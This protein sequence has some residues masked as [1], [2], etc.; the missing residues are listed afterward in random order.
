MPS[1][2][3]PFFL[4][5]GGTCGAILRAVDW[6]KNPLGPPENWTR[7]LQ[8]A[9]GTLLQSKHPMF[10]WWGKDLIQIYNDGYMP[11]FGLDRHPRAM[12][13]PG[14]ECWQDIW[15]VIG[16]QIE[17]VMAGGP[18][19]WHED[20]LVPIHRYGRVEEVYWTYSF[21]PVYDDDGSVGG[22][23]VVC[24]ETTHHVVA[25]RRLV[26]LRALAASLTCAQTRRE[27][28]IIAAK[29]LESGQ[30]DVPFALLFNKG[31]ATPTFGMDDRLI[32]RLTLLVTKGTNGRHRIELGDPVGLGP[33]PEPVT[34]V[35][36]GRFNG[37]ADHTVVFGVS[38]R[39]ELDDEYRAFFQQIVE[40][41]EAADG[42]A[43]LELERRSLLDQAPVATALLTG[44]DHVF[45]IANPPYRKMVG[46]EVLGKTFAQAFPEL[47]RTQL[48][49]IFDRVYLEG[50][51]FSTNELSI[52][53]SR[54]IGG[55]IEERYLKFNLEPVRDAEGQV[56]GMMCMALDVTDLVASRHILEKAHQE[57]EALLVAAEAAAKAKDEFLAMLGHELR[58]PLAP[59][60]TA[61]E[62]MKIDGNDHL[63]REREIIERQTR[64]LVR[65]VDDLLDVS[66]VAQGKVEI[67]KS[68]VRLLDVVER[69]VE[70]TSSLLEQKAHSLQMDVAADGLDLDAD[71]LR[72]AQA[73]TNLLTNAARYTNPG[74]EIGLSAS[75]EGDAIKLRVVDNGVGLPPEHLPH[76]FDRFFQGPQPRD[77]SIGGLG[78]GLALVKSLIELHG[79]T[80]SASS[81][82]LGR[83]SVFEITL[84]AALG[85]VETIPAPKQA[86]ED[87]RVRQR[88]LKVLLVDDNEDIVDLFSH[89]LEGMGFQVRTANDGPSALEVASTFRPDVAVLD[90]GLPVMDGYELAGL[91]RTKLG[92]DAPRLIAMSGYG[93]KGDREESARAGFWKHFVKPVDTRA[94]V[95][96]LTDEAK[97][98][99]S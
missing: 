23:L 51:P 70:M 61:L 74:G 60:V 19:T 32:E 1:E 35:W 5:G 82:G 71:P 33:W 27:V 39:L 85:S 34:D 8:S 92:V 93:Q 6:S 94:L 63:L 2:E 11:S 38:P 83:G 58:N 69:S 96:A 47:E 20:H 76:L 9:V 30:F 25:K 98:P 79:G 3:A 17:S 59:I 88:P 43:R 52:P 65:L 99:T 16:P 54:Y 48:P 55:P 37:T 73:L 64:H 45:E 89:I 56:Y 4:R 68:R 84:P 28:P 78:L 26:L 36:I 12:G 41:L 18:A 10:L 90:I 21:S 97:A 40:H 57:R 50:L 24:S 62:L 91:L 42:R 53:L 7:V 80:V 29:T 66:R 31:E 86:A 95:E 81:S 13:Q 46:R 77:R 72:L 15:P 75:R 44:P 14:R 87:E 67:K 49:A 22:T